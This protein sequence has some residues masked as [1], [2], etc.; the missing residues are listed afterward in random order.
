MV[1]LVLGAG[2]TEAMS[3]AALAIKIA[4]LSI[5]FFAHSVHY[6]QQSQPSTSDGKACY[7][8]GLAVQQK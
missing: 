5:S 7:G 3:L 4:L 1:D 6:L 8:L 2:V